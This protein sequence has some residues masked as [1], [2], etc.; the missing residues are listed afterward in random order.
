MTFTHLIV[1]S[2]YIFSKF[3]ADPA[4]VI[5]SNLIKSAYENAV[6]QSEEVT[7]K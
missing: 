3:A 7:A 2:K 4:T 1:T 6:I 5:A